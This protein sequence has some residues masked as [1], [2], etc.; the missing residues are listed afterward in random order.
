M[1]KPNTIRFKISVLYVAI[2]GIILVAYSAILYLS[3]HVILYHDFDMELETKA[4]E[5]GTMI[6]A[7]REML[8]PGGQ[9]FLEAIHK[10]IELEKNGFDSENV[11]AVEA[12]WLQ[13]IDRYNLR[14][15]YISLL[16]SSGH[17]IAMSGDFTPDIAQIFLKDFKNRKIGKPHFA[18]TRVEDR[19]LRLL[20]MP[21]DFKGQGAYIIE[22]GA[23]VSPT[24]HTLRSRLLSIMIS[25]PVVLLLTSFVGRIFAL[26][27]LRPVMAITKTA[28]K[29]THEDLTARVRAEQA[30][31]EIKYW[32]SPLMT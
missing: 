8:G 21:I 5:V 13:N 29:I 31:E 1:L 28:E 19:R 3:L 24:I 30:D 26:R 18:N 10:T 32:W 11:N 15:N 22:I 7:Y 14:Q 16:D 4:Q 27:I 23:S 20:H 25:I 9:N 12:K 17:R 6:Q 2:L